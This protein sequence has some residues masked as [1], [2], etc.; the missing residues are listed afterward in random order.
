MPRPWIAARP[1]GFGADRPLPDLADFRAAGYAPPAPIPPEGES[2]TDLVAQ[3]REALQIAEQCLRP[4]TAKI[5]GAQIR[6]ALAR[7][8]PDD[9]MC[10]VSGS[11]HL[12]LAEAMAEASG[13]IHL[14][15]GNLRAVE[16]ER[17]QLAAGV[18]T[19]TADTGHW[20]EISDQAYAEIERL[21]ARIGEAHAAGW[22][23]GAGTMTTGEL[24]LEAPWPE[25]AAALRRQRDAFREQ[26]DTRTAECDALRAE[27]GDALTA[28]SE[29]EA[30]ADDLLAALPADNETAEAAIADLTRELDEAVKALSAERTDREQAERSRDRAQAQALDLNRWRE[31][32][33]EVIAAFV[34]ALAEAN[35]AGTLHRELV[36]PFLRAAELLEDPDA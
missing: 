10:I 34:S 15:R 13:E 12:G 3:I 26:L 27:L 2:N 24:G 5:A 17:D 16:A 23:E 14:M 21:R 6:A 25:R 31:K 30:R 28:A 7:L 32:E 18:A 19:L 9:P 11:V 29:A 4:Q 36:A 1:D 33:R 35:A 8:D 20:R 22:L